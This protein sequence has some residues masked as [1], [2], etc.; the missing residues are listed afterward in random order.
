MRYTKLIF[1][2]LIALI[3]ASCSHIYGDRGFIKDKD[4][5]YLKAQNIAP[6]RI[7]P[8]Y[9][10]NTIQSIYPV[11]N[12]EYPRPPQNLDLTP[13]ELGVVDNSLGRDKK[14]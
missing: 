3:L 14:P 1:T 12:R 4:K 5:E 7:P 9:S 13:P 8:G 6:I 11:S 2:V 10:S